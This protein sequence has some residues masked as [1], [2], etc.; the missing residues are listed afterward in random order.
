ML[1]ELR[2]VEAGDVLSEQIPKG[3]L[4]I[5]LKMSDTEMGKE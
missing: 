4:S 3:F 5:G 2:L 1:P